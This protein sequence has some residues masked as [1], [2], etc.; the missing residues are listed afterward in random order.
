MLVLQLGPALSPQILQ[1]SERASDL[2][3]VKQ[4]TRSPFAFYAPFGRKPRLWRTSSEGSPDLISLMAE[5][6]IK[7]TLEELKAHDAVSIGQSTRKSLW[8]GSSQY[9]HW[10]FSRETLLRQRT[11]INESAVG[12]IKNA[13]E[14][15]EASLCL[16]SGIDFA[17]L[18]L[19]SQVPQSVSNS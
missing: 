15:D 3:V 12:A 4:V 2:A 13:F 16:S 11:Q 10:R 17:N 8:H 5:E 9:R 18:L 1:K 14:T 6:D 19:D 7:P